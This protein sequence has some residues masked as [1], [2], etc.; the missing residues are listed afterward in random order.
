MVRR[1]CRLQIRALL[2][3]LVRAYRQGTR[4]YERLPRQCAES[5]SRLRLRQVVVVVVKRG[6]KKGLRLSALVH[7]E[8]AG[9]AVWA[10]FLGSAIERACATKSILAA[11][12]STLVHIALAIVQ[13]S[14]VCTV[15]DDFLA[16]TPFVLRSLVGMVHLHAAHAAAFALLSD[17]LVTGAMTG[18]TYSISYILSSRYIIPFSISHD[19]STSSKKK[20]GRIRRIFMA[21]ATPKSAMRAAALAIAPVVASRAFAL[22]SD[23]ELLPTI[24]RA[25]CIIV[26][27]MAI[28]A[29]YVA[30]IAEGG[31]VGKV[32]PRSMMACARAL[33]AKTE[34]PSTPSSL[35]RAVRR[36]VY[37]GSV[38]RATARTPRQIPKEKIGTA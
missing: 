19:I 30:F 33:K 20:R 26:T 16:R 1:Q 6:L 25:A 29:T 12:G 32:L 27:A 13:H 22:A 4:L 15:R 37:R 31:S 36:R 34:Q 14:L 9:F 35:P 23:I 38:P 10:L 11:F 8:L 28:E 17:S 3:Q 24:A 21:L 5:S 18:A 7:V 2:D